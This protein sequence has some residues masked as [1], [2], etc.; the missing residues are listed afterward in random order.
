[1][2]IPEPVLALKKRAVEYRNQL[3]LWSEINSGSRNHAGLERMREALE[4]AFLR[5]PG[6]TA[7][8][9]ALEGTPARALRVTCRPGAQK[10]VLL[11]GHY[12]T[13]YGAEHP[14]QHCELIDAETLR[15]PGVI[16]MKGGLV[17]MLAALDAFE[18]LPE[19]KAL[20]WE[21]LLTPDEEIG[22]EASAPVIKET[23]R[24]HSLGL[25]FEPARSNG[26]LVQSRKG[27]GYFSLVCHGRAAHAG[28]VPND[29]RNAILALAEMVLGM[30]TLP[31][32]FPGVLVNVGQIEGGGPALN[33][34]P[35]L[36]RAGVNI[37]ISRTADE[38]R[39]LRRLGELMAP[40]QAR[41]GVSFELTGC[42]DCPPKECGPVEE[43]VFAEWQKAAADLGL[44]PFSWVH[45]GGGADSNLLSGEGLPNLDGLGPVGDEMHSDREFCRW[46]TIVER[47]QVAALFLSRWAKGEL[48]V[49]SH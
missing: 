44:A 47:A 26:D 24:R 30:Q 29:G 27:T 18:A 32:E 25:V 12:D 8:V 41:L 45:S 3:I 10:Q 2:S 46:R 37:R 49:P 17:T 20:G 35:D 28:H 4:M 40:L 48:A 14:F 21:V 23:A 5:F 31:D 11:N 7:E 22:S 16:D 36:A 43:T 13:V 6:A 42:I 34:V 15:G 1:M 9:I 38:A 19:A 33:V 39:V